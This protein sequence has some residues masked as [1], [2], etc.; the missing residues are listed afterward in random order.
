MSQMLIRHKGLEPHV[1]TDAPF[2]GTRIIAIGCDRNCAEC[3]NR[4]LLPSTVIFEEASVVAQFVKEADTGI[5]LGG[6]EWTEQPYEM[7]ELIKVCLEASLR[8]MIYT[9]L[10]LDVFLS[11]FPTL[12]SKD[13]YVKCG[14]Y[15]KDIKGYYDK[16]HDVQLASGNQYIKYLGVI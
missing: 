2:V 1:T 14:E 9:Y 6:L 8:I 5:I 16:Q 4:P 3:F 10:E 7:L 11:K 15:K 12:N 13:I